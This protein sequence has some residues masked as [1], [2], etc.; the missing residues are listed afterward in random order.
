M[1]K[2][3]KIIEENHYEDGTQNS[4]ESLDNSDLVTRKSEYR[5]C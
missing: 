3:S 5:M 2:V 1:I 4:P